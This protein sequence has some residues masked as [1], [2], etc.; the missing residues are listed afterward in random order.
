[1]EG[2]KIAAIVMAR[3]VRKEGIMTKRDS[4][5]WGATESEWQGFFFYVEVG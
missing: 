1:M 2:K 5:E 3:K 4:M